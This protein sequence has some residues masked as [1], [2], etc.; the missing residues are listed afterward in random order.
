MISTILVADDN[1][2]D[3]AILRNYL[4]REHVN[5]ISALNGKE[6]LDMIESRNVDV[7][8]LSLE[9]PVLDG[10]GFLEL[11]SKTK[12]Y[13]QIPII[14]TSS[15]QNIY[16][17]AFDYDIFDYIQKPLDK[18]NKLVFINKVRA[19]LKFRKVNVDL[20]TQSYHIKNAL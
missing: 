13:S 18:I 17:K 10:F 7:I 14:V 5:L 15:A 6:A 4:Y 20:F 19:A 1:A 9:M 3:N 11:F 16:E 8:I 2:L 12:L